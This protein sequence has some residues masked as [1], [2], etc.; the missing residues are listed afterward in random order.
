MIAPVRPV[1]S[2]TVLLVASLWLAVAAGVA[3]SGAPAR[4][5]PPAPQL[6]LLV[7]TA[8]LWSRCSHSYS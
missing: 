6:L 5:R 4:L 8:A 7:V 1:R 2:S 3:A